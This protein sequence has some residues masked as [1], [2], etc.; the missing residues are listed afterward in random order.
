MAEIEDRGFDTVIEEAIEEALDEPEYIYLSVDIDV[1]D[2]GFA[3]GTG[4]PEPGGILPS[5]L[6]R[7]MRRIVSRVNVVA[8]DLWRYRRPTMMQAQLPR[9]RHTGW[10]WKSSLP[11]R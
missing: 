9:S 6:L 1:L 5:Q 3:P 10:S 11:W 2:P 4:T 7:A 8:M